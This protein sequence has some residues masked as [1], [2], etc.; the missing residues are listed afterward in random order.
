M[1]L[2]AALR[3]EFPPPTSP[4]QSLKSAQQVEMLH[5]PFD[6]KRFRDWGLFPLIFAFNLM[7][8]ACVTSVRAQSPAS[9]SN[10]GEI[11]GTVLWKSDNRPA[12]QVVVSLRSHVAG[13]F[14]SILTDFDGRFDVTGLPPG[15]YE[16]TAEEAGYDPVLTKVQ[17]ED[18]TPNVVLRLQA[19][20]QHT[21]LRSN[22]T[23]SVRELKIPGKAKDEYQRGLQNLNKNDFKESL[24]H[25]RKA[26]MAFPEYY[27]AH[28]HAGVAE[29]RMG[30]KAEALQAFQ[31]AVELSEGRYARAEFGVAAVLCESGKVAEAEPM[32]RRG[33]EVDDSLPEGHVLLGIALVGLHRPEEAEKSVREALLRSANYGPAYLV[34]SEVHASR[35]EYQEQLADLEVYLKLQ[36]DGP[37]RSRA[38]VARDIALRRAASLHAQNEIRPN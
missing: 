27:E 28:Y 25:F 37:E 8:T 1:W 17:L 23:V 30:H 29:L 11:S 20:A 2:L 13:V 7:I 4:R 18:K 38:L 34:L 10:T 36:P 33:L 14:R 31:L 24:V 5:K 6:V 16:V 21:A 32:I 3:I 35:D 22:A 15:P 12:V 26:I 9:L 19:A